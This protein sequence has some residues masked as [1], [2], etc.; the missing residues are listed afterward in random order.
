MSTIA[1]L[2]VSAPLWFTGRCSRGTL[3]GTASKSTT[4]W[5]RC[6][7][8][9]EVQGPMTVVSLRR[10]ERCAPV[11]SSAIPRGSASS[12]AFTTRAKTKHN[13]FRCHLSLTCLQRASASKDRDG[14]RISTEV[15]RVLPRQSLQ[16]RRVSERI[17][18]F[19][20]VL[21]LKDLLQTT[22]PCVYSDVNRNF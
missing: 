16:V 8:L 12:W 2:P 9:R 4:P 20:Q 21:V 3:D 6:Q 13:P 18:C 15:T 5:R 10:A 11:R 22:K 14:K 17:A 7:W 1:D 19:C